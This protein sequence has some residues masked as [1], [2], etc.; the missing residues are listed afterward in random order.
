MRAHEVGA[1][2]E[3][4]R[5]VA[6]ATPVVLSRAGEDLMETSGLQWFDPRTGGDREGDRG[7]GQDGT[8]Y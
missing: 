4:A 2:L 3:E 7:E 8:G 5:I 6:L 1:V